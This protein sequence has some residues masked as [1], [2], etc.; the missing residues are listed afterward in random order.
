MAAASCRYTHTDGGV[1]SS[2][3]LDKF[4]HAGIYGGPGCL[5]ACLWLQGLSIGAHTAM[6]TGDKSWL[7]D[8]QVH[9]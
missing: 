9:S 8:I 4:G 5:H 6:E 3:G 1:A 7:G 2:K